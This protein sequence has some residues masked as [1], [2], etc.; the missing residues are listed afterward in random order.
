MVRNAIG[1]RMI[2][3]TNTKLYLPDARR[4]SVKALVIK[5][6]CHE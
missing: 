5:G 2:I 4:V 1:V 6:G 3:E